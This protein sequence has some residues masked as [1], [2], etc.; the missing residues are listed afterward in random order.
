MIKVSFLYPYR[1]DGRFDTRYY[2]TQHMP[3]VARLL[4][5]AL[6][7]YAVEICLYEGRPEPP[8]PYV[9][10]GHMLFDSREAFE[11]AMQPHAQ[12]LID[13]VSHFT[14]GGRGMREITE[15]AL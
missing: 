8:P 13:D 3:L 12:T 14:D 10:V 7:N 6:R 1:K 5:D 9:A 4:G 11:T 15:I 2:C